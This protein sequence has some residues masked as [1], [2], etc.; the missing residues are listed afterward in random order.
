MLLFIPRMN[1]SGLL[2]VWVVVVSVVGTI[3]IRHPYWSWEAIEWVLGRDISL[4]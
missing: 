3:G 1:R 4:S 2:D